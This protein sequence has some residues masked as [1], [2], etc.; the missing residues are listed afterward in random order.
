[1]ANEMTMAPKDKV[2]KLKKVLESGKDQLSLAMQKHMNPDRMCRFMLTAA[3]KTPKLFDCSLESIGLAL[4]TASQWGI[5]PD[6][7]QGYLIPYG[8]TCQFIPS[9]IGLSTMAQRHPDVLAIHAEVV[10]ENDEFRYQLGLRP[11]LFHVPA[12]SDRGEVVYAWAVAHMRDAPALIDVMPREELDKRRA[13]SKSHDIWNQWPEEMYRKTVIRH[14]SKLLP[15]GGEFADA[16]EHENQIDAT[17]RGINIF[18]S[19]IEMDS[20]PSKSERIAEEIAGNE[21]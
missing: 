20:E 19:G 13:V 17:G 9:Y 16:L 5:E 14:I 11:D 7:R 10:K 21:E 2:A 12:A 18:N 15:V 3:L 6:G 8:R 4:L 1:M